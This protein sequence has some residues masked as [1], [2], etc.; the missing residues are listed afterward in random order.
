[1]RKLEHLIRKFIKEIDPTIR[2]IFHDDEM[3][4]M[5]IQRFVFVNLDEFLYIYD[6][7]KIH[8]QV[9]KEKGMLLDIEL[10]IFILLHEVGH[11]KSI[12]NYKTKRAL[13]KQYENQVRLICPKILT[14]DDL[15]KYKNT[16]LEK[17]ADEYAYNFYLHNYSKIKTFERNVLDLLN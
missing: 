8:K 15:R 7:E 13:L 4:S 17:M 16:K 10:P 6:D 1:M 3:E 14:I 5:P 11:I 2:V 12:E 9:L